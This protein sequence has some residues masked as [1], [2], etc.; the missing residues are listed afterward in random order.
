V[1]PPAKT[2]R[3]RIKRAAVTKRLHRIKAHDEKLLP[4][5]LYEEAVMIKFMLLRRELMPAKCSLKITR[6]TEQEQ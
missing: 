1:I 6:S 3:E 5:N 4:D 2:G